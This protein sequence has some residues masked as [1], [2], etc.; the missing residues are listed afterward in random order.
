MVAPPAWGAGPH[1]RESTASTYCL[2]DGG[3]DVSGGVV[4][5]FAPL[6][7]YMCCRQTR[8]ANTELLQHIYHATEFIP[9][10]M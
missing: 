4:V 3:G 5:S 1:M 6:P 2:A 7:L 8:A 9:V 10:V